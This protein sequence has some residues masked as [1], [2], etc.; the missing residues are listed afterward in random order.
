MLEIDWSMRHND[1]LVIIL[2]GDIVV[3]CTGGVLLIIVRQTKRSG[4]YLTYFINFVAMC[5][6]EFI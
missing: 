6:A 1:F 2:C 5:L 3:F 4:V